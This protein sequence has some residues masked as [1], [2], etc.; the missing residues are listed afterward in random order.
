LSIYGL[1]TDSPKSNT[2]FKTKQNLPY[3]L[4]CDPGATLIAAIGMK[5]APKGTTRGVFVIEKSGKVVAAEPG[6][7]AATVET[8]KKLVAA[9]GEE[10]ET[11]KAE[12]G[13]TEEPAGNVEEPKEEAT[14]VEAP[15]APATEEEKKEDAELAKVASDVADTAAKLDGEVKA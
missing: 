9:G 3:P 10:T 8:V 6:S 11:G 14:A 13:K 5:K 7:P 4:L 2:T 12:E 1:S 15:P